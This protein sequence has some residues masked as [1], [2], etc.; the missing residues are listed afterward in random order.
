MDLKDKLKLLKGTESYRKMAEKTGVS[1]N[2]L[3]FMIN[4]FDPKTNKPIEPSVDILNKIAKAYP[5]DT[6]IIELLELAGYLPTKNELSSPESTVPIA[7]NL[8]E[9]TYHNGT[10]NIVGAL[11][12][13][14]IIVEKYGIKN[15]LAFKVRGESMNKIVPAASLAVIYLTHEW[16]D[17]DICAVLVDNEEV[18]LKRCRR[19]HEGLQFEPLS[20]SRDFQTWEYRR[21]EEIT[22]EIIGRLLFSIYQTPEI[23]NLFDTSLYC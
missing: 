23:E 16:Q 3:R 7:N 18:A 22:V 17:G 1:H 5:D 20:F 14:P 8:T 19:T 9:S 4:G 12:V 11:P 13:A 15:L 2:Y 21:E 6:S 10:F